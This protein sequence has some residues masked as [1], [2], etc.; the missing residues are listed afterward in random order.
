[1]GPR[2]RGQSLVEF[3]LVIPLFLFILLIIFDFGRVIY[4]QNAIA[5]DAREGVRI[6]VVNAGYN[7]TKYQQIRTAAQRMSPLVDLTN[8]NIV[9][10]LVACPSVPDPVDATR[11]FYLDAPG[12]DGQPAAGQRVEVNISISVPLITP[13][14]SD[15]IGGS[16]AISAKSD[17]YIQCSGC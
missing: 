3:A 11:C 7:V 12:A 16:V 2:S 4:A 13:I 17:G 6:A 1:M 14:I 9:G 5:N 8:A 15:L 10:A